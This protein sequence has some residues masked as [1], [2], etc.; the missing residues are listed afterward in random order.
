MQHLLWQD[1][2]ANLQRQHAMLRATSR[3]VAAALRVHQQ[4][5]RR[6]DSKLVVKLSAL[7]ALVVRAI[8]RL[9]EGCLDACLTYVLQ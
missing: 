1:E 8:A 6:D 9:T 4:R 5:K 2:V 7:D 3:T